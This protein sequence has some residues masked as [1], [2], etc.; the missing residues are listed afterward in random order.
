MANPCF[1]LHPLINT[2]RKV[3]GFSVSLRLN[4]IALGNVSFYLLTKGTDKSCM[5]G[6]Q[7]LERTEPTV[8]LTR[9]EAKNASA[10]I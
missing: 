7:M 2:P 8:I 4:D 10:Y 9:T 6:R 3:E 1:S 5:K